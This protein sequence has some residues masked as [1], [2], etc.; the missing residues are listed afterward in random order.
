[1]VQILRLFFF[2]LI[3][4][5]FPV[6]GWAAPVQSLKLA[7][8]TSTHFTGLL[9][10]LHPQF[11]KKHKVR[12]STIAAGTGKA[13]RLGRNGDVDVVLVHA[14]AAEK[15]FVSQGYGVNRRNV[16]YN[17]FVL[18]GPRTD[19]ARIS[20]VGDVAAALRWI[21]AGKALWVSRG[22]DSGTHKKEMALWRAAGFLPSG[23]WYRSLGQGMGNTLRIADEKLAYTLSDRGSFIFFEA[24]GKVDLRIM[25]EGDSRLLNPYGVIAVNP[26]RHPHVKYDLAMKYVT[27]L[28]SPRG[29]M[30]IGNFRVKGKKLFHPSAGSKAGNN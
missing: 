22:D 23:P 9:D 26:Q 7:T 6:S 28:T 18:V 4:V 12:I 8:T 11:E 30:L 1:M 2:F 29:Q 20:G 27:F 3:I 16:M 24:R 21:H 15:I 13:L 14:P 25:S 19:P 5:S 10:Y 17:D